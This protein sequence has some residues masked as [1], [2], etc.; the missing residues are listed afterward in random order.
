[1]RY[2]NSIIHACIRGVNAGSYALV[3][4][5]KGVWFEMG[6]EGGYEKSSKIYQ[7]HDN[8]Y[9]IASRPGTSPRVLAVAVNNVPRVSA[10]AILARAVVPGRDCRVPVQSH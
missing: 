8:N 4:G 5:P 1:M 2:K 7:I 3:S 6:P 9:E 10:L